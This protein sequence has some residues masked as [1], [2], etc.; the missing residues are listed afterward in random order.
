LY[1]TSFGKKFQIQES[2]K[3]KILIDGELYMRKDIAE[4]SQQF[5]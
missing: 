5:F 3:K 4:S 2:E 1:Q